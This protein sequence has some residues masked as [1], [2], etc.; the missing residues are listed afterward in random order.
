MERMISEKNTMTWDAFNALSM[1]MQSVTRKAITTS[2]F[3]G[4]YFFTMNSLIIT[5]ISF[6]DSVMTCSTIPP[7][8]FAIGAGSILEI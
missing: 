1:A 4:N 6:A 5:S 7:K 8:A 2:N 3:R